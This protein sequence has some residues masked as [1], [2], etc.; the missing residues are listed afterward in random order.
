MKQ[1]HDRNGLRPTGTGLGII[2]ELNPDNLRPESAFGSKWSG[3]CSD[4]LRPADI[5][6][7]KLTLLGLDGGTHNVDPV[8]R[9][10][11]QARALAEP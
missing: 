2:A 8:A 3:L 1:A 9:I 10:R 7:S 4:W 6:E 5:S 11:T